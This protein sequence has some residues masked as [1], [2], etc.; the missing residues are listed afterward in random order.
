MMR[1]KRKL[2]ITT[3]KIIDEALGDPRIKDRTD[4]LAQFINLEEGETPLTR[5][6]LLDTI[7][8]SVIAGRDTTAC[9]LSWACYILCTNPEIQD[10]LHEEIVEK[11]GENDPSWE[12]LNAKNMPYLNGLLYETFRLYP[13]VP[14]DYKLALVDLEYEIDGIKYFIPKGI[15]LGFSPYAHGRNPKMY[16]DPL[17]V[18]PNRWIPFKAPSAYELPT[19]QGGD[20]LCLGREMAIFESK[21]VLC[22]VFREFQFKLVPGEAEKIGPSL[23]ATM[24]VSNSLDKTSEHLWVLP[25]KRQPIRE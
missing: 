25:T 4:L 3:N 2:D 23:S 22:K 17:K 11:L 21:L 19:F 13:P 20:R 9:T 1:E 14:F 18:D 7:L 5:E 10:Q 15:R 6:E 8:N 16:K 12:D 24:A